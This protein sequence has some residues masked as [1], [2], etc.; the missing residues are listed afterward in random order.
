[1][2]SKPPQKANHTAKFA[3]ID[4]TK[5]IF[6]PKTAT[7]LFWNARQDIDDEYM[8]E[9][10]QS[11]QCDGLLEEIVVRSLPDGRLQVVCGECRLRCILRLLEIKAECYNLLV[12]ETQPASEVFGTIKSKV[13]KN[14]SDKQA[15]RISVT[16]NIKRRQLKDTDLMAYCRDLCEVQ[17][18][19]GDIAYNRQDVC[20]ILNRSATWVSQTLSLYDLSPMA[21]EYLGNG[22]LPRTVALGLLKVNKGC[23]DQVVRA[24]EILSADDCEAALMYADA[25]VEKLRKTLDEAELG[26]AVAGSVGTSEERQQARKARSD[27][28]RALADAQSRQTT[29]KNRQ[30]RLTTDVVSRATDVTPGARRGKSSGMSHKSVR[31]E[32]G[33]VKNIL[34]TDDDIVHPGNKQVYAKRDIQLVLLG[35]QM[36]LGETA[37]RNILARLAQFYADEGQDGWGPPVPPEADS[38]A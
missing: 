25:E 9:L 37:E 38:A 16:E 17:V 6:A 15:S 26:E 7:S 1:M 14:C 34:T 19:E 24:A 18:P 10:C 21:L 22:K 5:I 2:A 20:H 13:L 29:A 28:D 12:G 31:T 32:V 27:T 11:I 23:V 8:A 3:D 4:P 36:V 35:M 33:R 30:A